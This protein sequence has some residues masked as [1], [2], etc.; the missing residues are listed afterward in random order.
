MWVSGTGLRPSGLVTS[1]LTPYLSGPP[2]HFLKHEI[3]CL[4]LVTQTSQD[5]GTRLL[6]SVAEDNRKGLEM[7]HVGLPTTD[8]MDP[9]QPGTRR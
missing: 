9:G 4:V 3:P 8:S 7:L 2:T 6:L 1:S 5:M